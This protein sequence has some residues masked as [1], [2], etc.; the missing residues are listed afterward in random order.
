VPRKPRIDLPDS[1]HHVTAL[2]AGEDQLF[3]EPA[4]QQRFMQHLRQVGIDHDWR[5]N[6]Y[7]LMGTHFH[8]I[9]YTV[10]ATLSVG[11]R[12]LLGEYAQ[13]FNWKYD[14]RGHL[15]A[16]RFS[17][18]HITDD[19][20]LLEAHRYVALNPVR[21]GLCDD[22]AD[23]RWGSY[24]A[25]AGFERPD[26]FLDVQAVHGLFSVKAEAAAKAYRAFVL[27][28]IERLGSDPLGSDPSS[29]TQAARPFEASA[30]PRKLAATRATASS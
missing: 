8:L 2:A 13:W 1:I 5:C 20:Y 23:W 21:A 28:G 15:F 24:R 11:M 22:P 27:S 4:D 3:R 9:E 19:A 26:D 6:A 14:R 25:L 7:C 18:R 16:G 30:S 10:N 12:R 29:S 17:S